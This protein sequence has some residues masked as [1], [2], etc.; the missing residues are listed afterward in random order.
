MVHRDD[1]E[2]AVRNMVAYDIL[3]KPLSSLGQKAGRREKN[4]SGFVEDLLIRGQ[5]C[6]RVV[7]Y[8]EPR[9]EEKARTMREGIDAF[10]EE[11]PR[12]GKVLE[13][14]IQETRV[15]KNNHLV[16]GIASG[17]QLGAADYRR[18]MTDLGMTTKEADSMYGHLLEISDRLG[19]AREHKLRSVLL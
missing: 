11:H 5:S 14:M 9:E 4:L 16:F 15:Q 19:K 13:G 17:F 3:S 2:I 18:V 12:Y 10:K 6:E 8:V 7:A 1:L